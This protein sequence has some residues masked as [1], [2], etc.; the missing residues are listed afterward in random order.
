MYLRPPSNENLKVCF[1]VLTNFPSKANESYENTIIMGNFN[2]DVKNRVVDFDKLDEI[3]DLFN[4]ANLITSPTCFTKRLNQLDLILKNKDSC[5][6]KPKLTETWLCDFHRLIST[7][8]RSQFCRL[9]PKK[10]STIELLRILM[11][12]SSLKMSK[13]Q[14]SY[15][16]QIIRMKTMN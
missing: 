1:E 10:K 5:F 13:T 14:T 12:K 7:F 15:S 4:L 6:E 8:L 2:T 3:C 16:I 9:I 11:S